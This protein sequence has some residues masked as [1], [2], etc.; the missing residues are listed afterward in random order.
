MET[1]NRFAVAAQLY[2]SKQLEP[3]AE[4]RL[5]DQFKTLSSEELFL[6]Q[7][8]KSQAQAMGIISLDE[9]LTVYNV[10]CNWES[11]DLCNRL[12]VYTGCTE[13]VK[14]IRRVSI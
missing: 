1:R 10:L 6:F 14:K 8:T 4:K 2:R 11:S 3:A 5:E 7:E 13:M 12:A 9:A